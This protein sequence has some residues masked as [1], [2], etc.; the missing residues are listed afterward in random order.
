MRETI[1]GCL[2]MQARGGVG[3]GAKANFAF[4]SAGALTDAAALADMAG[5]LECDETTC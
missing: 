4:S 5:G 2:D 1:S 3:G